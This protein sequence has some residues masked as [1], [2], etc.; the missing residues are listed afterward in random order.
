LNDNVIGEVSLFR[1][2]LFYFWHVCN[3]ISSLL[4]LLL[5]GSRLIAIKYPLIYRSLCSR[6]NT[7]KAIWAVCVFTTLILLSILW[8]EAT[9]E[10][11]N[12]EAEKYEVHPED[13]AHNPK[14]QNEINALGQGDP[15][16]KNPVLIT[17][18]GCDLRPNLTF[19]DT[20]TYA[21]LY[22][23]AN[24]GVTI[25]FWTYDVVFEV[26]CSVLLTALSIK[27]V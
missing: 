24:Y 7:N 12:D 5:A 25:A 16:R 4:T 20:I 2:I 3:G 27:L 11:N 6:K 13:L 21:V 17:R 8:H 1:T 19:Y 9:P 26:L 22:H 15:A 18:L 10:D 14:I 23:K